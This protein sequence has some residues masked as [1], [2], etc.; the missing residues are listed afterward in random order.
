M[1][2]STRLV[3]CGAVTALLLV[4]QAAADDFGLDWW[5]IDGGGDTSWSADLELTG[6]I[7][8]HDAGHTLSGGGFELTGG[9]WL[10]AAQASPPVCLG[11]SN[12]DDAINWR[13]IDYFVAGQND[14]VAGWE[15]MFAPGVPSCPFANNDVNEDGAVNWR[16]ID[17]LVA[18]MNTVCP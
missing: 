14:N 10:S 7:G 1:N 16:D 6:T 12:C 13:D 15:A 8:Q 2:A 9:F 3:L 5:T 17:P 11:D 18:L 4:A